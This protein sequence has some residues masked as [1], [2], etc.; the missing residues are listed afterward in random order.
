MEFCDFY[1]HHRRCDFVNPQYLNQK[2][3]KFGLFWF[4][5]GSDLTITSQRLHGR[6]NK[7]FQNVLFNVEGSNKSRN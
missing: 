5:A 2:A 1:D 4:V 7:I 3:K 6:S